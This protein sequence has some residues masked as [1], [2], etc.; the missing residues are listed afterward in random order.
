MSGA[1]RQPFLERVRQLVQA[2]G[3]E[4]H[5][6]KGEILEERFSPALRQASGD[7]DEPIRPFLL[8]SAGEAQVSGQSRIRFFADRARVVDQ[9]IG[10]LRRRGGLH[11]HALEK[12]RDALRVVVVHLAP[13]GLRKYV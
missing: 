1:G 10:G 6:H 11:V 5:I 2:L 8:Q 3:S 9:Q 4:K 13:E 12:A 7:H